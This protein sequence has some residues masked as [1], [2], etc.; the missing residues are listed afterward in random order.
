MGISDTTFDNIFAN[1]GPS[2]SLNSTDH[3]VVVVV[4]GTATSP[5]SVEN[6]CPDKEERVIDVKVNRPFLFY[7]L[8]LETRVPYFSG[9]VTNFK[10]V[11][12]VEHSDDFDKDKTVKES[13]SC[14]NIETD[15]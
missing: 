8:D 5:E 11:G 2:I 6:H 1:C 14:M 4:N 9:V 3:H 12:K 10:G 15:L 7:I 13:L